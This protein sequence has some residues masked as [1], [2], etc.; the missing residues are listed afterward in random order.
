MPLKSGY[1]HA[2]ISANIAELLASGHDRISAIAAALRAARVAY[3]KKFPQGALPKYL[4]YPKEKRLA[5]YYTESGYPIRDI[6]PYKENPTPRK[7]KQAQKLAYD[8]SG[9][10][11]KPIGKI[12]FPENPGVGIA[13]GHV[14]GIS[15]STKRDG[16]KENYYHA[17]RSVNSRPLLVSSSDGKQLYLIGGSYSFTE[18]GIVDD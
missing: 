6:T 1:S 13:I 17:F 16:V 14:L 10:K 5:K 3:F 9:H 8:F 11:A 15:Y 7:I 2:T 18:R 4:A 12:K